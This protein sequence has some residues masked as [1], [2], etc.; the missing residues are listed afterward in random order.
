[1]IL[2][3]LDPKVPWRP[4]NANSLVSV[5]VHRPDNLICGWYNSSPKASQVQLKGKSV[6]SKA[7]RPGKFSYSGVSLQWIR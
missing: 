6:S 4:R 1:M 3:R 2:E 5:P 7:I